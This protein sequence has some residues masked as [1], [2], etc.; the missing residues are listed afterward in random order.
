[1][2]RLAS[3]LQ[4]AALV[5]GFAFLY[6]PIVAAG[7]LFVQRQP[8]GHRLGRLLHR[9]GTRRC[10]RTSRCSTRSGSPCGSAS[11]RPPGDGPRH[12][13]GAAP[14]SAHG[15]FRGRTAVRRHGLRAAGDAGGDPWACRCCCCSSAPGLHARLLDRHR[16]P[17]PP[18]PSATPP[19]S[20]SPAAAFD[21]AWRRPRRT[22]APR[23]G[24]PSCTV[25]LPV[26]RAGRRGGLDAGLHPVAR[27][28]GDRQ[29]HLRP[30]RHHPA[31]ADLQPGAAGRVARRSTP[32]RLL[33]GL[34][35]PRRP[36]S[37]VDLAD[38]ALARAGP[39]RQG[40]TV[41]PAAPMMTPSAPPGPGARCARP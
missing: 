4:H 2:T 20:C 40:P 36:G 25:T 12:P 38:V 8:A 19:W 5:L 11:S 35:A 37:A 16:S 3:R 33:I 30:R 26:H 14:S 21:R 31:D 32:S 28:S 10:S 13:G 41:R 17:T 23:P 27:R 7:R 29:L 9:A 1:M 15:R 18:S 24:A 6:L 34:V 22:S 39:D